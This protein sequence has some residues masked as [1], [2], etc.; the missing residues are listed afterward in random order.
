MMKYFVEGRGCSGTVYGGRNINTGAYF[1]IN[2]FCALACLR[3]FRELQIRDLPLCRNFHN[4][5]NWQ[6]LHIEA[7]QIVLQNNALCSDIV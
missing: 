2:H 7:E 6:L 3:V 1:I 4:G 5:R